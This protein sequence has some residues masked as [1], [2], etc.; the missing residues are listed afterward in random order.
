[1]KRIISLIAAVLLTI[2]VFAYDTATS[3]VAYYGSNCSA[4]GLDDGTVAIYQ[5]YPEDD[6]TEVVFPSTIQ[7]WEENDGEYTMTAEYEVSAVGVE[8]WNNIYL[9]AAS[10]YQYNGTVTSLVFS[11]GIKT[12]NTGALYE[13]T[14]LQS[15]TLPSTLTAI[16]GWAFTHCDAL[17]SIVSTS[18]AVS[19]GEGAFEGASS[20][21]CI[22]ANCK[23]TV[24]AGCTAGYAAYSFD[25][26][27][28]WT[29]W[30]QFY[31]YG[32]LV[33]SEGNGIESIQNSEF[34]IKDGATFDLSGRRIVN[35]NMHK[36]I[37]IV[38]GKKI[39]K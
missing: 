17:T 20:W 14:S 28:T 16:G 13:M 9:G 38:K 37:Y 10:T 33:E 27:Q 30:D 15:V 1:M 12:I 6:Q 2:S 31:A 4:W 35:D 39:V 22:A 3:G 36:G 18:P 11:E 25:D 26:T 32:N 34:K 24:P 8:G 7:V 29:Y 19:L 21:D 5:Y 23:V